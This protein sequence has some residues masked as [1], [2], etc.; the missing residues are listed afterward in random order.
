ML[1]GTALVFNSQAK[2][3]QGG[4]SHGRAPA[5]KC[6]L[7]GGIR[8]FGVRIVVPLLRRHGTTTVAPLSTRKT[9]SQRINLFFHV[10][11]RPVAGRHPC[12]Y[13]NAFICKCKSK[14]GRSAAVRATAPVAPAR[15]SWR[16]VPF[17]DPPGARPVDFRAAALTIRPRDRSAVGYANAARTLRPE[18]TGFLF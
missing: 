2:D 14:L 6:P 12:T 4:S 15:V 18:R 1:I 11:A 16:A 9:A 8:R 3:R 5:R 10:D 17:S 7:P 13:I